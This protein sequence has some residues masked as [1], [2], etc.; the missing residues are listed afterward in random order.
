MVPSQGDI[1]WINIPAQQTQGSEQYGNRPFIVMSRNN[2]NKILKTVLVVP[3]STFGNQID[4][5]NQPPFRIVIPLAEI[6]K[7]ATFTGTLAPVSIAKTDQA[8]VVDKTRLGQ[9]IGRLS[10]TAVISVGAGLAFVFDIR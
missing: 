6:T 2:V 4:V 7:D 5:A 9:K 1:H 8:R 3:M 10:H